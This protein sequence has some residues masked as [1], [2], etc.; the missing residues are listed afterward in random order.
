MKKHPEEMPIIS[1]QSWSNQV[2]QT[3]MPTIAFKHLN[4]KAASKKPHFF[5]KRE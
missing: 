3:V 2:R 4:N 5:T 1:G